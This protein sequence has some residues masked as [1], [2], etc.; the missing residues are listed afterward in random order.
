MIVSRWGADGNYLSL[1][2]TSL[3][4]ES[5]EAPISLTPRRT[6]LA[7]RDTTSPTRGWATFL[8]IRSLPGRITVAGD[9]VSAE[10]YVRLYS[11]RTDLRLRS[12]GQCLDPSLG[13]AWDLEAT[14]APWIGEFIEA[15]SP[16]G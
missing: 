14:R 2:W 16:P 13:A 11:N 7:V 8:L 12:R 15:G 10:G 5:G 4:A 1:A 3:P 9:F 6:A